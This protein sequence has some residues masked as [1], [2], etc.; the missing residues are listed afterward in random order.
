[1]SPKFQSFIKANDKKINRIAQ[2][3]SNYKIDSVP[4]GF[5]N[6]KF[7]VIDWLYN[8]DK[9]GV[10]SWSPF[11]YLL[12]KMDFI[13]S[14]EISE[15]LSKLS[16]PFLQNN[17]AYI[18]PLG[19]D[20]ESS[21][22]ISSN[23]N[24]H[25]RYFSSLEDLLD[26]LPDRKQNKILLY[27]DFLNSGGQVITIFKTLLG[28]PFRKDE[29]NDEGD[30]RLLLRDDQKQKLL[31]AEIHLFYYKAF[32]D[33]S[34]YVDIKNEEEL[35][36][37]IKVHRYTSADKTDGVFGD[38]DDR[39]AI[40]HE[41][42]QTVTHGI[43]RGDD[44]AK[45]TPIYKTLKTVGYELLKH[46]EPNW[47]TDKFMKR[48]LGYGN[49][50]RL[51]IT[52]FNVPT[53]TIT[54]LWLSGKVFIKGKNVEWVELLPRR[55]KVLVERT[56]V[57]SP[58]IDI[59][60]NASDKNDFI[61]G[62]DY[63]KEFN[64]YTE[65]SFVKK[66]LIY[67][68]NNTRLF[69]A[70]SDLFLKIGEIT[71]VNEYKK[72]E[73]D[74]F[75]SLRDVFERENHL[76]PIVI[77]GRP[78][79][80]RTLF[81]SILYSY[82][83]DSFRSGQFKKIPIYINLDYFTKSVHENPTINFQKKAEDELR[84]ISQKIKEIRQQFSDR[85]LIVLIDGIDQYENSK[86][87]VVNDIYQYI[88]RSSIQSVAG[89][90]KIEDIANFKD[91]VQVTMPF[92]SEPLLKL[93]FS[94]LSTSDDSL[95]T[96]I[97]LY[98][99][100]RSNGELIKSGNL[101][102]YLKRKMR[103]FK[104]KKY[105]LLILQVLSAGF[106]NK[107]NY[108]EAKNFS[109]YLDTYF[110]LSAIKVQKA[111][112]LAHKTFNY[113]ETLEP[114]EKNSQEWWYIHK[115]ETFRD[116][117]I[118]KYV[119]EELLRVG[120]SDNKAFNFVYPNEHNVFFKEI[121]NKSR[122]FQKKA[123]ENIKKIMPLLTTREQ[124]SAKT[125]LCYL[126]G[127]FND[128]IVKENAKHY[129]H[130]LKDEIYGQLQHN[131][132]FKSNQVL[133]R[134]Q[135]KDL[136]LHRTILISLIYIGDTE[137]SSSYIEQ[138]IENKYFCNLNRGFHLEYYGDI[139]FDPSDDDSLKHEDNFGNYCESFHTL[140][141][142][143]FDGVINKIKYSMFEI[144]LYTLVSLAQHRQVS[145]NLIKDEKEKR[146]KI[147]ELLEALFESVINISQPLKDYLDFIKDIFVKYDKVT[148]AHLIADIFQIKNVPR[149]GW[150]KS[151]IEGGESVSDHIYGTYL[152]AKYYLPEKI[153]EYSDYDKDLIIKLLLDH[154]L[155]EWHQGDKDA[156]IK[157]EDEI[158]AEE[159]AARK[160]S[161]LGTYHNIA[162][163]S[164]T[165]QLYYD[166]TH[167]SNINCRIARD[168]DRLEMLQQ[169]ATYSK[170]GMFNKITVAEFRKLKEYSTDVKTEVGKKIR[171]KMLLL[172][173]E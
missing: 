133:N 35:K 127:R 95:N 105:D 55:K 80:G 144:E 44:S 81:M 60:K 141:S 96:I 27:D 49:E 161:L 108:Q 64:S 7:R 102:E 112:L 41:I 73:I 9:I 154:D 20:S 26:A 65:K 28:I 92:K 88:N 87:N 131:I 158:I 3:L 63:L 31:Q 16:Q 42:H 165:W 151:G 146:V 136:L 115:N 45:I 61:Y 43:F 132:D 22:R 54:S 79:S 66:N 40:E 157:T 160:M 5:E 78:G 11:L 68:F 163:V 116:Y 122:D 145:S 111:G 167:S 138:L 90:K 130:K 172:F 125:H 148:E 98:A 14:S 82:L 18:A 173:D 104:I 99:E 159:R 21:F 4:V 10:K 25:S 32:D 140:H 101:S 135:K 110:L 152:V 149:I 17:N 47:N 24:Q 33:G 29:I 126:L 51:I 1:M 162:N 34:E 19:E 48:S 97:E 23:F 113:R 107:Y 84:M 114:H 59:V 156:S 70:Y 71:Y 85:E 46:N 94:D 155:P 83:Y 12:E 62:Y 74:I 86:V 8:F 69:K 139:R 15:K 39:A 166:F 124:M 103:E 123:L 117:F 128:D 143:V 58:N 76:N 119:V 150:V 91:R 38:N 52:D 134:D 36:L 170:K 100:T 67:D 56:A 30:K 147:I 6:A 13:Q 77:S 2:R 75:Q 129:L 168:I 50:S 53:N 169:L 142:R 121:I 171:E 106:Y 137:T 118:A 109:S 37:K 120:S 153:A 93:E 164:S 57:K 72:G 89:I